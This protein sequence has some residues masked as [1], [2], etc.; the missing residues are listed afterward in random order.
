ML[1]LIV[2]FLRV[3]W[4]GF[5]CCCRVCCH[6]YV[7]VVVVFLCGG[8]CRVVG[9]LDVNV[10]VVFDCVFLCVFWIV[11]FLC[12][13][14]LWLCV[15]RFACNICVVLWLSGC[16]Y[17]LHV[18]AFLVCSGLF[19]FDV[20]VRSVCAC[21]SVLSV[22]VCPVCVLLC[23]VFWLCINS[24]YL[25]AFACYGLFLFIGVACYVFVCVLCFVWFVVLVFSNCGNVCCV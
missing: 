16:I 20:R 10:N 13:C 19:V 6:V 24:W 21:F 18:N 22:I 12:V 3:L 9:A 5:A 14:L 7:C 8:C 23:C 4:Y 15:F 11:V 25:I 1:H 17:L 2:G